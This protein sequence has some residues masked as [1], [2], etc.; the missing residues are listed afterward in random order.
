M[1]VIVCGG[2][3]YT[4]QETVFKCL[5]AF[6]SLYPITFLIEGGQRGADAL[7]NLWARTRKI[8]YHTEQ[9]QWKKYKRSAGAIRNNEMLMLKPDFVIAFPG[10]PG[11]KLMKSQA[12]NLGIQVID[13]EKDIL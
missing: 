3:L 8:P 9:A 12:A 4:D 11:T 2:R 5:D 10:G 1:R 13:I 6:H 7:A